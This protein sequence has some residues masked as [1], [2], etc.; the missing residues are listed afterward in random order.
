LEGDVECPDLLAIMFY[1]S[2]PVH[3]LSTVAESIMWIRKERRVWSTSRGENTMVKFLRL[4]VTD[5]YNNNMGSV[6]LADQY[7]NHYRIDFWLRFYKW[8]WSIF[9]WGIGVLAV[10]ACLCY[11]DVMESEGIPQNKWLTHYEFQREIAMAWINLDEEDLRARRRRIAR[12]QSRLHNNSTATNMDTTTRK[13]KESPTSSYLT[14]KAQ[15]KRT[16]N[17][18]ADSNKKPEVTYYE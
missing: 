11:C 17:Q 15:H 3:F 8:W 18:S 4:D 10:N 13:Q 5:N 7:Q 14:P 9:I 6:D 2:K 12:E 1:D 16:S